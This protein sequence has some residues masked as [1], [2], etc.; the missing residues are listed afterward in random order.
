M[1]LPTL[2]SIL[3]T[4]DFNNNRPCIRF[5]LLYKNLKINDIIGFFENYFEQNLLNKFQELSDKHRSCLSR[6]LVTV[7]LDESVF[8]QWLSSFKEGVDFEEHYASF[9]SGQ[10]KRTVYGFKNSC[11]GVVIDG[12]YYPLYFDYVRK[13]KKQKN[14]KNSSTIK[15]AINIINRFGALKAQFEEDEGGLGSLHLSADSGYNNSDFIACCTEHD[16][17]YI[18]VPSKSHNF[19]IDGS[20]IKLNEWVSTVFLPLEIAYN[21]E[22]KHLSKEKQKPFQLRFKG[23]YTSKKQK[24]TLLAFR[25]NGSKNVSIIYS[26]SDTIYAKT[27]R[28]HWFQR[29]YIEQFFKIIKHVLKIQESRT[30]DKNKFTFKFLRFAFMALHIQL[31]VRYIRKEMKCWSKKGFISIQRI[32][33]LDKDFDDLLQSILHSIN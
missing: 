31:L 3:L 20:K 4:N 17:I 23:Y 30:T 13:G 2:N 12:I 6:D 16:L 5:K 15:T 28:R 33:R 21:E 26:T 9:F 32:I 18:G 8:K 11:L 14:D 24:V 25:L 7:V 27:L 29:T 1:D 19:E 22:Q 10:Y